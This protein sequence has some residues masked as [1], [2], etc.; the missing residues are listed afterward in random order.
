MSYKM[1]TSQDQLAASRTCPAGTTL[2]IGIFDSFHEAKVARELADFVD[3]YDTIR[4]GFCDTKTQY[5]VSLD[6]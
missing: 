6:S 2:P 5:R 4:D 1:A 3:Q